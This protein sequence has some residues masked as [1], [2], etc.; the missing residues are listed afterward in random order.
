MKAEFLRHE[1]TWSKQSVNGT[2]GL[3][4]SCS[5]TPREEPLLREMEKLAAMAE[6]D[7]QTGTDVE[8][9]MYS[10]DSGFVKMTVKP[11]PPGED[12]RKN[13]KVYLYQCRDRQVMDP[14]VYC[15]PQGVWEHQE[16]EELAPVILS[17]EWEPVPVILEKYGFNDRLPDLFR[18]VFRCVFRAGNNLA[19]IVPWK[20][21][22][23]ALCSREIMYAIH[24]LLPEALRKNAGYASYGCG[25]NRRSSFCFT[26]T[27]DPESDS[28]TLPSMEYSGNRDQE[29]SLDDFFYENLAAV[30]RDREGLY[31]QFN[32]V[33]RELIRDRRIDKNL[34]REIQWAFLRFCLQNMIDIP[35]HYEVMNLFPQLFYSAGDS[36]DL[37]DIGDNLLE[38]YHVEKWDREEL[39][40]Y[41]KILENGMT[42][43]GEDRILREMDWSLVRLYGRYRAA[44]MDYLEQLRVR[45]KTLYTRLLSRAAGNEGSISFLCFKEHQ[46]DLSSME[47]YI[48][49]ME[50]EMVTE[51][52]KEVWMIRGIEILNENVFKVSNY[53]RMTRIADHILWREPWEEVLQGFLTQLKD[54]CGELTDAQLDASCRIES[55]CEKLTGRPGDGRLLAEKER[56][57]DKALPAEAD[58]GDP[59]PDENSALEGI[60]DP[61]DPEGEEEPVYRTLEEEGGR[62][63]FLS[64]LIR[65]LPYGFLTACIIYLLRYALLIGHW[66]ISIGVGGMW[67]ILMLNYAT[68][69]VER[70]KKDGYRLWQALGLCL[71]EG[72]ILKTIAWMILP[73]NMRVYFF[74]ALG[75]I[76][77]VIQ[78]ILGMLLLKK[79]RMEEEES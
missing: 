34:L 77:V 3:G 71:I 45:N 18:A 39:E 29:D 40:K 62:D 54:R 5:S 53:E 70:K 41:L 10:V 59:V 37:Q 42:R 73:Q 16:G 69:R 50:P 55:I 46:K 67:L 14:A 30:F 57:E 27:A 43:K 13:K 58:H 4:I 33:V 38:Y 51:D 32:E 65:G 6:P 31:L 20:R 28:F 26:D 72:Y 1:Y 44:A 24:S 22:D 68:E 7:S 75:I 63:R 52:A 48:T 25:M 17:E 11:V 9:L 49:G 21:E 19:F 56:R 76:I 47:E 66:K 74:L 12:Q 79:R 64:F 15:I 8:L 60:A 23:Y 61:E 2:M 35:G 78:C 36:P